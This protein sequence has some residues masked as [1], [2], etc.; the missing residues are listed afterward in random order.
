MEDLLGRKRVTNSKARLIEYNL[1]D[2][3][4]L[5]KATYFLTTLAPERPRSQANC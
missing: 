1:D 4:A 5:G 3:A 2:C